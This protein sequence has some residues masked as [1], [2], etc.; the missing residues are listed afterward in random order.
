[1][2]GDGWGRK[3]IIV[4]GQQLGGPLGGGVPQPHTLT[5]S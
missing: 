1:M 4:R 3:T 5:D 2:G